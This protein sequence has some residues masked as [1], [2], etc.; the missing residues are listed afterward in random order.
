M[1]KMTDLCCLQMPS[2]GL[3]YLGFSGQGRLWLVLCRF[4]TAQ[5]HSIHWRVVVGATPPSL[6]DLTD[7]LRMLLV[8]ISIHLRVGIVKGWGTG[9]GPGHNVTGVLL[10]MSTYILVPQ[11]Q[12]RPM[13]VQDSSKADW[14]DIPCSMCWEE[15]CREYSVVGDLG[16]LVVTE[17]MFG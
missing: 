14:V 15:R 6:L 3:R 9:V 4:A 16:G 11:L 17:V 5:H 1:A 10:L 2:C 13:Y 7:D 12:I 8:I